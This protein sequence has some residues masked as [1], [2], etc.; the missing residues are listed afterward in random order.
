MFPCWTESSKLQELF[1]AQ[2]KTIGLFNMFSGGAL[3]RFSIFAL[4]I[5]PYISIDY[6]SIINSY[7]ATIVRI[8]KEGELVKENKN[9]LA[10]ELVFVSISKH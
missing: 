3:Q 8:K 4:G 2:Q 6:Y 10:T 1:N 5:M 7:I 9:T